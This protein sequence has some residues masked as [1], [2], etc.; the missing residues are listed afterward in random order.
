MEVTLGIIGLII[1]LMSFGFGIV[2]WRSNVKS[3]EIYNQ[4]IRSLWD[5]SRSFSPYRITTDE[6]KTKTD[7]ME[8]ISF[9][10]KSHLGFSTMFRQL[11]PIYI[12]SVKNKLSYEFIKS[13]IG[14]GEIGSSWTLRLVLMEMNPEKRN[15]NNDRECYE[16]LKESK[17]YLTDVKNIMNINQK[18]MKNNRKILTN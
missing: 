18:E 8:I 9:I 1:T 6:L 14:N 3:K 11:T 16:F 17:K 12:Q 13:M 7:D 15:R 10:E 2:Q 5:L 4:N